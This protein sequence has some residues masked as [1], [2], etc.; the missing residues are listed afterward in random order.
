MIVVRKSSV[1]FQWSRILDMSTLLNISYCDSDCVTLYTYHVEVRSHVVS[2]P[3]NL[4]RLDCACERL[5]AER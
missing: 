2:L 3:E 5:V 1:R 4:A